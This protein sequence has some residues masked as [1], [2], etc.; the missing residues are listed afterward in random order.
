MGFI[1][2][3]AQPFGFNYLGGKLLSLLCTSHEFREMFDSKYGMQTC[4]FE[5]TSLYG[6]IKSSSQYDGLQPFIR[7]TGD[8]ESNFVLSFSDDFWWEVMDWF[9]ERNNGQP[10]FPREGVASYKMKMQNA[11]TGII[12]NSLKKHNPELH[13]TFKSALKQ[14]KDVTTKKRFYI[15]TYGFENTKDVLLGNTDTLSKGQ[16]YDKHYM[17]NIVSWWKKKASKRY[18]SLLADGRLR[19]ELEYWTPESLDKIDIIR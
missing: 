14:N 7:Y 15:S 6:N 16:N 18:E 13:N 4:L 8:T 2:V 17:E 1:I 3:P 5:T 10:L 9:A 11:M 12:N 19:H